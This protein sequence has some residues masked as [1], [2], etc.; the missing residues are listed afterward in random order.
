MAQLNVTITGASGFIGSNI[1]SHFATIGAGVSRYSIRYPLVSESTGPTG[2]VL[3]H[4]AGIAHTSFPDS[5]L[6]YQAN[7]KLPVQTARWAKANGY[8]HFVFLSTALVWDESLEL[9]DAARDAPVPNTDYG[10][11]KL[12]AEEDISRLTSSS[13]AVSIVR[14]PLVYGPGVKGNL[15]RLIDAVA[16]WPVCPL[17]SKEAIRSVTGVSTISRFVEHLVRGRKTGVYTLVD[18]PRLSTFEM[19][20]Y[21]HDAL[22]NAGMVI[23]LP[24]FTRPVLDRMSPSI[25]KRLL[26]SRVIIDNTVRKT[27]FD[28]LVQ[29]EDVRRGFGQMTHHRYEATQRKT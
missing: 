12:A 19:V 5:D 25:A 23:P 11:A 2:D 28:P 4:C 9:I 1:A 10:K 24:R 3:I 7:H 6:V 29:K 20:R 21:A 17:G 16:K 22:P 15:A 8:G 14:L 26:H 13:F 27:G 18:T